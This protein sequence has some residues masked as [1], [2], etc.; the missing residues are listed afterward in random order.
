MK[1]IIYAIFF[2]MAF[3]NTSVFGHL[4][5]VEIPVIIGVLMLFTHRDKKA[6]EFN[7][8]DRLVII[9]AVFSL[10]SV[11]VGIEYL[12][13]SAR[14][15]RL[16]VLTPVLIYFVIRFGA[17]SIEELRRGMF[18][19]IPGTVWQGGLLL[20]FYV[21]H[22]AR[23]VGVEGA[24]STITL[25][26]L[27]VISL[28]ILLFNFTK[29][30][31][32]MMNLFRYGLIFL[33][34]L[35][36]VISGT[37][38]ALLGFVIILV[39]TSFTWKYKVRR[40]W[41]GRGMF[42]AISFLL[43]MVISGSIIFSG[44]KIDNFKEKA[45]SVER[46]FDLEMLMWD[47]GSRIAFWGKITNQALESP[48]FGNG[49]ASS[50]SLGT[51]AGTAFNLGSAHNVLVSILMTSGVPGL[52]ILLSLIWMFYKVF[53]VADNEK[54]QQSVLGK[55]VQAS[56]SVLLMVAVTNDFSGGRVFIWFMFLAISARMLNE[57][58]RLSSSGELQNKID[59][60][61]EKTETQ[62]AGVRLR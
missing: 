20:Q 43:I 14:H 16:M 50:H 29:K 9:Y 8:L 51:S 15:Y 47:V 42:M 41:I 27:I 18:F 37:R 44:I 33:L 60:N 54:L 25:S 17:S 31:K 6:F 52:I 4:Y 2:F 11:A 34:F 36:L 59:E 10:V 12:Y 48:L 35:M 22:G 21:L 45:T 61:A 55:P 49:G 24:V 38:A 53:N 1:Y 40:V 62:T 30:P 3:S 39:A 5:L 13:E 26:M 58:P 32:V 46:V 56:V 23:P 7:S 57:I 19:I 28:F